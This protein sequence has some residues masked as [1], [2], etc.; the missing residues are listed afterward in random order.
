MKCTL[1][2]CFQEL[3]SKNV[4]YISKFLFVALDTTAIGKQGSIKI[5]RILNHIILTC[6]CGDIYR[7]VLEVHFWKQF[8]KPLYVCRNTQGKSG[9]MLYPSLGYHH[10]LS[11]ITCPSLFGYRTSS[12]DYTSYEPCLYGMT[13]PTADLSWNEAQEPAPRTLR[14]SFAPVATY[15]PEGYQAS[16]F[17]P[18][19]PRS[20]IPHAEYDPR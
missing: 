13:S 3:W 15:M 14:V 2:N 16:Y 9:F 8:C 10:P 4:L 18:T 12:T 20:S 11:R 19:V 1:Q 17:G 5:R 7:M 6:S